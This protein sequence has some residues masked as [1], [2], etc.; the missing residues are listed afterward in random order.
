VHGSTIGVYGSIEGAFDEQTPCMPDNIYGVTKFEG[1]KLALSYCDRIPVVVIRIPEVYGPGDRRLLK[2][3]KAIRRKAFVVIGSGENLHHLI[4]I[5]D[6]VEG[7]LQSAVHPAAANKLFLLA[8]AEPVTTNQMVAAIS[9]HLGAGPPRFHAPMFPF[10]VAAIVLEKTLRPL[11]IQPPLHRRR[12]DF[13]K[14]SFTLSIQLAKQA[15]GFSPK[16]D[17][18]QGALKTANWYEEMGYL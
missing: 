14:K 18:L 12:L 6:L 16:E 8:G 2:L 3:F 1:E 9:R 7:L 13:F 15:F 17:F 5:D 4:Y 11:G 10:L